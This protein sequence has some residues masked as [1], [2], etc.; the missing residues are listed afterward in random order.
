VH[1]GQCR[2]LR[3]DRSAAQQEQSA[4]MLMTGLGG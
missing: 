4:Q 2:E 3:K 1:Q